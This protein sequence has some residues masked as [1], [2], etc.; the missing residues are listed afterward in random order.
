MR[1]ILAST[2]WKKNLIRTQV[3]GVCVYVC[4]KVHN[5]H[6]H[7]FFFVPSYI[8]LLLL[9]T[10]L[11]QKQRKNKKRIAII[12]KNILSCVRDYIFSILWYGT[13]FIHS[14]IYNIMTN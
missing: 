10:K 4:T 11:Q 1:I 13:Q 7:H 12:I 3:I 2:K 8:D 5:H 9:Y 14:F 6:H